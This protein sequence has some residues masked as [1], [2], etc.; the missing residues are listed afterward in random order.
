M[1]EAAS[2][3]STKTPDSPADAPP[4]DPETPSGKGSGDENFPV[5]S[6]LLPKALRP[7]VA[8]FYAFAR[9]A[10]DIADNGALGPEDKID[11]L[12]ALEAALIG[13]PGFGAAYDKAHRLR[14]SLA[15]TG[16]SDRHARDLVAA[17]R[18]DA[19]KSRYADWQELLGYCELSAN[20]VGR[21]LLDLHGERRS[22]YEKSDALCTVLQILNHLQDCQKDYLALDRVYIPQDWM[23]AE[24][25]S[26]V[27]LASPALNKS[28]RA[29]LDRMLA[30]I[31]VLLMAARELPAALADRRLAMESSTIVR[32]AVRLA[33]RLKRQD[34]LASRVALS[35]LDF[36]A[37]GVAGIHEG[38]RGPRPAVGKA[39]QP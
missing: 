26:V 4:D 33:S 34:P 22:G 16:V 21:F 13:R 32:L 36:L 1:A 3:L 5:G 11:R 19:V 31:D 14:E 39:V 38:W 28:M 9:A 2:K 23:E 10:D 24:G 29:V 18:Q 8:A 12:N 15:A 6:F 35:K 37:A 25:A 20:P 30:R 17:F 7:H 27:D